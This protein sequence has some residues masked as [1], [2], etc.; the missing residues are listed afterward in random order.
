MVDPIAFDL[1]PI[2]GKPCTIFA[3]SKNVDPGSFTNCFHCAPT[4]YPAEASHPSSRCTGRGPPNHDNDSTLQSCEMNTRIR[5]ILLLYTALLQH[6]S[7]N[8]KKGCDICSMNKSSV[9]YRQIGGPLTP[10]V[11]RRTLYT[12]SEDSV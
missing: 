8:P 9:T 4:L 2:V 1:S 12:T 11:A 7:C 6:G 3:A 10:C 5:I